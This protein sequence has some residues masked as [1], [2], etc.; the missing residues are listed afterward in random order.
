MI[1]I[2]K[3]RRYHTQTRANA[4]KT[5]TKRIPYVHQFWIT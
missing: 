2:S 4:D 1:A 5:Q 3:R